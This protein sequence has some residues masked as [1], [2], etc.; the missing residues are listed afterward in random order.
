MN[1]KTDRTSKKIQELKKELEY[2][3]SQNRSLQR[4]N[5]VLEGKLQA[6]KDGEEARVREVRRIESELEWFKST[7]RIITVPEGKEE[8][9]YKLAEEENKGRYR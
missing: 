1:K 4:E 9:L 2:V 7:L 3:N 6:I 5:A 8:R